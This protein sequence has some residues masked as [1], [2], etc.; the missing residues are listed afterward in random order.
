M[1]VQGI[2]VLRVQGS[3]KVDVA[4]TYAAYLKLAEEKF[5]NGAIEF[6]KALANKLA[7]GKDHEDLIAD[8]AVQFWDG[9]KKL[10]PEG[11]VTTQRK[12][13]VEF[14]AHKLIE[15]K[16]FA[17]TKYA[18]CCEMVENFIY[19]NSTT[20][21]D[22][23]KTKVENDQAWFVITTGK[24]KGAG[25]VKEQLRPEPE[26]LEVEDADALAMLNANEAV[27]EENPAPVE[28]NADPLMNA[29]VDED[30]AAQLADAAAAIA[31]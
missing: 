13:M 3:G 30:L 5:R 26:S 16:H 28:E 31:D 15:G 29:P 21:T 1:R 20:Y 7:G 8:F 24:G 23:E 27:Q 12:F 18:E 10:A 11:H 19:D 6:Q 22:K 4:G 2:P 25:L 9:Y 17:I 14:I